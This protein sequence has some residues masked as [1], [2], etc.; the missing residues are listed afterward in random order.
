M[1]LPADILAFWFEG[2]DDSTPIDKGKRPFNKWFK[3]SKALDQEIRERFEP[4]LDSALIGEYKK[5]EESTQ[6]ALTLILLYDQFPRNM[7]RATPRMYTGD[8]LAR[9]LTLRLTMERKE[10]ALKLIEGTFIY[11]PLMHAEDLE[12]QKLS[13]QCF[14][15]L[16]EE[17][18][19][20]N[21]DN[22][23]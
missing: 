7:Y 18:K 5:W 12:S 1:S 8:T 22:T 16:A 3:T 11:M 2:V 13:V 9:G 15:G 10:R 14:A 23:Q 6:G 4:D 19:K 21:P 17:S 20:K